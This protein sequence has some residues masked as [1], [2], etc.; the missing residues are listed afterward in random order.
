MKIRQRIMLVMV[1]LIMVTTVV[2]TAI[3]FEIQ[4]RTLL[5][6][7]DKKLAAAT[8]FAR[9]ILPEQYHDGI[10]DSTSVSS[11]DYL[12]TVHSYNQLCKQLD[13]QYIWSLMEIN[14]RIVFTSGTSTSKD[15]SK[16]DFASF[17]DLHT[18]PEAYKKAFRTMEVQYS[19]F[20]DRWGHG[21]MVLVP[22]YDLKGRKYLIAASMGIN[23]VDAALFKTIKET[24]LIGLIVLTI[25]LILAFLLANSLSQP[26]ERLTRV[27]GSIARGDLQQSV[28]VRGALELQSLSASIN[29][30]S[31]SIRD[32]IAELQA[33]TENLNITLNSIGDAVIA[34]D[35][36]GR[37]TR[38]NPV[39]EQM[40][41]WMRNEATGRP[42]GAVFLHHQLTDSSAGG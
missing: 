38:M 14:G 17:F 8:V 7:I 34:T 20:R 11:K 25:A 22:D 2:F 15:I 33:S 18:N 42:L 4:K 27:A 3:I 41:G 5:E 16:G 39:A 31:S 10:V 30:M 37:V 26:I 35:T 1:T 21:R 40:T 32:K 19:T 29:F 36:D 28:D 9:N 6:G 24:I 23:E 13:I 12:K